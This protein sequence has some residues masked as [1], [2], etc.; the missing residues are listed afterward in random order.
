MAKGHIVVPEIMGDCDRTEW[1][2]LVESAD[3]S[4]SRSLVCIR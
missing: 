2:I 3:L 4:G 1:K